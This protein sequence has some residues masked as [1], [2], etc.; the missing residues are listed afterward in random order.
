MDDW[1]CLPVET[2]YSRGMAKKAKMTNYTP[3]PDELKKHASLFW[4]K[5]LLAKEVS[6][7]IIPVLIGTQDKFIS[8]LDIADKSPDAWKSVLGAGSGLKATVFL[9]QVREAP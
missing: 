7:S 3:T 1:T 9:K 5:E 8:I 4:P 6:A 2:N